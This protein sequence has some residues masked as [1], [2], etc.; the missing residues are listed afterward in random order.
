MSFE[1][2]RASHAIGESNLHLQFT[3]AYRRKIFERPR[4]KKLVRAY[5]LIKAS[6]LRI[7]VLAFEFGTDHM[8]VFISDWKKYSP[9]ELARMLKGFISYM[10]RKNNWNMFRDLLWGKKFWSGG[11]F[12]RTVGSVTSETIKFYI[13]KSQKKHWKNQ[14]KLMEYA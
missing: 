1:L 13:E 2:V 8:H 10:M 9:E 6:E 4:V 3:P 5:L 14:K 7:Q 11:Y 12:Y